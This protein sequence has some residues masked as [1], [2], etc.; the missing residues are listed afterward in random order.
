MGQDIGDGMKKAAVGNPVGLSTDGAEQF[1]E[2]FFNG[3]FGTVEG[4]VKCIRDIKT[5]ASE[6]ETTVTDLKAHQYITAI[7]EIGTIA[8]G[9]STDIQDCSSAS[10]EAQQLAQQLETLYD[11]AS[12]W[13]I[14]FEVGKNI[15]VNGVDIYNDITG[16]ISSYDSADYYTMGQDIGNAMKDAVVGV[17][18]GDFLEDDVEPFVNGFLDGILEGFDMGLKCIR[19]AKRLVTEVK[20]T[21]SDL[22]GHKY[23]AAVREVG[24]IAGELGGDIKDCM[25]AVS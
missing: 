11:N 25:G 15:L 10:T 12:A 1:A 4:A 13:D 18:V 24:T 23:I 8:G 14:T 6:V 17:Q 2:G 9:L 20:T 3:I 7:E 5:V 19:D 16:A 22:T 21:V